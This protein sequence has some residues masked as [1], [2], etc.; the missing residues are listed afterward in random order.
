MNQRIF[1]QTM[2]PWRT[3]H[4]RQICFLLAACALVPSA[5]LAADRIPAPLPSRSNSVSTL[6]PKKQ[7][8]SSVLWWQRARA[9]TAELNAEETWIG[10]QRQPIL[11]A[12]LGEAWFHS[13]PTLARHW[14]ERAVSGVEKAPPDETASDHHS[15]AETARIV[16][17]IV[18]PLDKPLADRLLKLVAS[19]PTPQFQ[20]SGASDNGERAKQVQDLNDTVQS[21][22]R[23]DP[24]RVAQLGSLLLALRGGND[25]KNLLGSL[26]IRGGNQI[27]GLF[28]TLRQS[29][30]KVADDIF[31]QAVTSV[32]SDYDY[33]IL[34]ALSELAFPTIHDPSAVAIPPP[35]QSAL[36]NV[37]AEGILRV[38]RND[39][40]RAQICQL[41]PIAGRLLG[42]FPPAEMGA[43]EAS[44]QSCASLPNGEDDDLQETLHQYQTSAD[45]LA[46]ATNESNL[47][48]RCRYKSRAAFKA[49]QEEKNPQAALDIWDSFTPEELGAYPTWAADRE[50]AAAAAITE[51]Y[52]A[53]DLTGMHTVIA[54]TP[55]AQ[56]PKLQL[57]TAAMLFSQDDKPLGIWM[58]TE[59]RRSLE[60]IAVDDINVYLMLLT[61][62]AAI[63]PSEVPDVFKLTVAGLNHVP[64]AKPDPRLWVLPAGYDLRPYQFGRSMSDLDATLVSGSIQ[65]LESPVQRVCFRLG[66]LRAALQRYDAEAPKKDQPATSASG[67]S[68]Q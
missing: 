68:V 25:I 50:A 52:K 23:D 47:K 55:D 54:R 20:S 35:L 18:M 4:C 19:Q 37:L 48:R 27:S 45:Y 22:V 16:L 1:S 30:Q 31:M 41:S 38:P 62:Y 51:F 57:N 63:A 58:L 11:Q 6:P 56:R 7:Q 9:L 14:L 32:R 49:L 8:P 3:N 60:N 67:K 5:A 46:A 21:I 42:A 61:T 39:Q 40:E 12:R 13:D 53:H 10:P 17:K 2:N 33:T 36:L 34:F 15:R 29:N 65:G 28:N 59:A 64:P 26:S 44:L 43:V 24:N 66:F